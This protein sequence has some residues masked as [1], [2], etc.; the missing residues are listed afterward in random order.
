MACTR[1][2][3]RHRRIRPRAHRRLTRGTDR[4]RSNAAC[5]CRRDRSLLPLA[6]SVTSA[7]STRGTSLC[8]RRDGHASSSTGGATHTRGSSALGGHLLV[9]YKTESQSMGQKHGAQEKVKKR[10]CQGA[11]LSDALGSQSRKD[12]VQQSTTPE[13]THL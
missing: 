5:Q 11:G 6:C 2:R 12:K 3:R 4:C 13:A 9:Q 8:G 10:V 7:E 1:R